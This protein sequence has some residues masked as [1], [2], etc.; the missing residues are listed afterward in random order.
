MNWV[1]RDLLEL[2]MLVALG[3]AIGGAWKAWRRGNLIPAR[4]PSCHRPTSRAYVNCRFCG[5][6]Q[7]SGPSHHEPDPTN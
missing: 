6:V 3:G 1:A 7:L 4:C 5:A 2:A